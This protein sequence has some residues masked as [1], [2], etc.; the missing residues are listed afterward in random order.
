MTNAQFKW[1]QAAAVL[2]TKDS[3]CRGR[4]RVSAVL[5]DTADYP[6]AGREVLTELRAAGARSIA[7]QGRYR[8][9]NLDMFHGAGV[10]ERRRS[11]TANADCDGGP[12]YFIDT[13]NGKP[14]PQATSSSCTRRAVE[15]V[16]VVRHSIE[17]P[18]RIGHGCRGRRH[19]VLGDSTGS[20][21]G[22][23]DAFRRPSTSQAAS[24]SSW[25]R[26]NSPRDTQ[27]PVPRHRDDDLAPWKRL[28]FPLSFVK[29]R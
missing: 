25:R 24:T 13:L 11:T 26:T 28:R 8:T 21:P 15:D 7:E 5:V 3:G 12:L 2:S 9:F 17:R 22:C 6:D 14:K 18:C 4:R 10:E 23:R 19:G 16:G 1:Q 27:H 20:M 29:T